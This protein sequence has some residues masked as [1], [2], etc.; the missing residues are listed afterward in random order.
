[1]LVHDITLVDAENVSAKFKPQSGDLIALTKELPRSFH[2]LKPLLLAYVPVDDH[3]K[4]PV[5]LSKMISDEEKKSLGFGVFLMNATTNVRIWNAL[6]RE[7]SKYDL[8]QS[9]LQPSTTGIEQT[10]SSDN[11]WGQD[12][13]DIIQSTNLNPSQEGAILSCLETCNHRHSVK[14]IWG[15]PGT[16]KTKTVAT[17]LFALL[18]LKRKTVVCAPTNTA[19]VEVTSRLLELSKKSSEHATYG[20]G[21]IVLAGNRKRMGIENN[22]YLRD[23]FLDHRISK[24]GKLSSKYSGWKRSLESFIDFLE[25]TDARYKQYVE[26]IKEAEKNKEEA[27]SKKEQ[28]EVVEIPTFE[29]YVKMKFN[30]LGK[31]LEIYMVDLYTHLPKFFISYEDVEKL[32][33][34]RQAVE[35]VRDFLQENVF[36]KRS[37]K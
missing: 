31:Q 12:V 17:L 32:I 29:E 18:N 16:G 35:R 4:I 5:I 30:G 1:M 33:A 8:I 26:A 6:H 23:V 7:A 3:P 37:Y 27:E 13:L 2:D 24:L 25:K 19:I 34:A 15:P 36:K 28:E 22:A 11:S 14:L 10:V 9:V 21:N 20:F